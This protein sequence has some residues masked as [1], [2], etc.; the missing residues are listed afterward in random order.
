M[1]D[2]QWVRTFPVMLGHD[3][4]TWRMVVGNPDDYQWKLEFPMGAFPPTP[5]TTC[6]VPGNIFE[7]TDHGRDV[8]Q[9]F[10]LL[11][12]IEWLFHDCDSCGGRHEIAVRNK[13]V[14]IDLP[15][16]E[17]SCQGGVVAHE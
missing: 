7:R 14:L 10:T 9:T 2:I 11:A 15:C 6:Y 5:P 1:G 8:R 3:M 12:D 13:D 17:G 4:D 16:C